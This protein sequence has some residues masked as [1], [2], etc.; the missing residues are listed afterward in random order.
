[1]YGQWRVLARNF[2]IVLFPHPAGPVTS[3]MWCSFAGGAIG[4]VPPLV[5]TPLESDGAG[6]RTTFGDA[7]MLGRLAPM[8]AG[9][10]GFFP[11]IETGVSYESMAREVWIDETVLTL[12][13]G[14]R[15]DDWLH[16]EVAL[17]HV[18]AVV[19]TGVRV[20]SGPAKV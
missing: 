19:P 11:G 1:M 8:F 3:Q 6:R 12:A 16:R 10:D 17:L 14:S 15:E 20:E 9:D 18:V 2:A 13:V 4:A 5:R 7:E